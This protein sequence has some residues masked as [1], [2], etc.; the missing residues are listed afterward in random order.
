M[1][2]FLAHYNS[3]LPSFKIVLDVAIDVVIILCAN[4]IKKLRFIYFIYRGSFIYTSLYI[5]F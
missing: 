4:F 1:T 3:L 5:V 2:G